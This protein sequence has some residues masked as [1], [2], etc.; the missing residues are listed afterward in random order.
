MLWHCCLGVRKSIWPVKIKWLGV[1]VV[2]FWSELQIVCVWSRWC[3]CIRESHH[4]LPLLNPDWFLPFW[5]RLTQ[6]VL[7]EKKPLNGCSVVVVALISRVWFD[8][9]WLVVWNGSLS[10]KILWQHF[11]FS[12]TCGIRWKL[13]KLKLTET[14]RD[15]TAAVLYTSYLIT[16]CC[17][18]CFNH[19]DIE[20]MASIKINFVHILTIFHSCSKT[21]SL[22]TCYARN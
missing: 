15:I 20:I 18:S 7:V 19:R 6:V 4:L 14:S 8:T 5:Y 11:R 1:V 12:S 16:L 2:I 17:V 21:H 3:H 22:F 13:V 10:L 9:C